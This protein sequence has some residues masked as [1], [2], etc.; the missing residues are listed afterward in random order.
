MG[1]QNSAAKPKRR[2]KSFTYHT[3]LNWVENRA[4]MLSSEEKP[5][6]RV[7]SPPEFK[8]EAGVWTPEDLFVAAV[9]SCTFTTFMAFALHRKLPLVSYE[10]RAEGLLEFAEGQ[11]QFTRVELRPKIQVAFPEAIETAREILEDAHKGCL[12]ANSIK[13]KVVIVPEIE[14]VESQQEG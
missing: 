6:F 4:A 10:S 3:G 2:Y 1:E 7:A 11:Y 9:D 12:V 8:G 5:T 14:A 13:T